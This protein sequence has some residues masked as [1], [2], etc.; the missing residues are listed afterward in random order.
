MENGHMEEQ[1]LLGEM[2]WRCILRTED[3]WN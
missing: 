1:N 2:T 3:R